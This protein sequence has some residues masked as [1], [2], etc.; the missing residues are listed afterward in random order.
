MSSFNFSFIPSGKYPLYGFQTTPLP[1]KRIGM[2]KLSKCFS[3]ILTKLISTGQNFSFEI[4]V[5]KL[6]LCNTSRILKNEGSKFKLDCIKSK[7]SYI[8]LIDDIN[9]ILCLI[10]FVYFLGTRWTLLCSLGSSI[11]SQNLNFLLIQTCLQFLT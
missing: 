2:I 4:P 3:A 7:N 5:E 9:F 6:Y 8:L 1:H 10:N 11:F